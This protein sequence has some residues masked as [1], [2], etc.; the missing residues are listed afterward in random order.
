MNYFGSA[1]L[2]ET[3]V[4]SSERSQGKRWAFKTTKKSYF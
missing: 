2:E 3:V 1:T 4:K